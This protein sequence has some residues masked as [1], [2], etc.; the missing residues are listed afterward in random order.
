MLRISDYTYDLP[1]ERI[2]MHPMPRRDDSK[3]LIYRKGEI[4]HTEFKSLA[5]YLPATST[6]FFNN[7]R[8]IR[9]RLLFTKETGATIEVFLL[10]PV[11]PSAEISLAMKA[12]GESAWQCSIGNLKRWNK[13]TVLT[14]A[15]GDIQ[16]KARL[17]DR[18]A[19]LVE[20]IWQPTSLT[21][22]EILEQVGAIPLPPYIKRLTE[23]ND[24]NRYQTI[25]SVHEGAVAAPTAGLHFTDA[26]FK[27][28]K[29]KGIEHD[30]LTLHVS[31]G[32]FQPVKAADA[33]QHEMHSEQIVV[34]RNN[35]ISLLQPNRFIVPVGTTAMRT[36]ESLYWYG[37]KL[38]NQPNAD[39]VIS[40]TEPYQVQSRLPS[41]N[42]ALQAVLRRIE[43]NS[44]D[45][46]AGQTSMYIYPGYP[47][48]ICQGL[49]TNFHLPASTLI[50]LVA[51][52]I[53]SDW[54]QVYTEALRNNYRFLSYGDSSFLIP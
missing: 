36:L 5:D 40:Q 15:K 12:N 16:L 1:D 11:K 26:V 41:G 23:P 34:T 45:S 30:F 22:A 37:V 47:F 35:L 19:T 46:I 53:G 39:F 2:A 13:N 51:A 9:A 32:T 52:F 49:I 44:L 43:I 24:A 27:S 31:A 21:L 14:L 20:L 6:L 25:Y 4:K 28:M 10:H 38:M 29:R 3:L 33:L 42:D 48:R 50:L 18:S 8:V 17:A 54:R 7:T